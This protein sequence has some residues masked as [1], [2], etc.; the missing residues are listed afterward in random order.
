M[1]IYMKITIKKNPEGNKYV[2]TNKSG[3]DLVQ[4]PLLNK[5]SLFSA[6]EINDLNLR[7]IVTPHDFSLQDLVE[8]TFHTLNEKSTH[9][10]KHIYL[11][12][13]QD[14]NE[15]LF[16]ALTCKYPVEL[17]PLIYTPY[18]GEACEKF[19]EIYRH[20]RGVFI[21]YE[22]RFHLDAILSHPR[23]NDTR[24]IVVSDGERILG[25]GD[26]G[27]GG[28]GIPIGKLS[29]Y[30]ACAGIAPQ[31]TLPI[32]LDVGTNNENL[33]ANPLYIGAR[34]KRIDG[35]EYDAFIET[36]INT[37]KK[38]FPNVVLQWE[39]FAQHHALKLLN[40]YK[41]KLCSFNDDIQGTA[42][43]VSGVLFAATNGSGV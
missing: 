10:E 17:M 13:L 18:V 38:K 15:T 6:D 29:L 24:M 33:L 31:K 21:R 25:L 30:T 23:F 9:L 40:R 28:M 26:Q 7:G 4:D 41:N 2:E 1:E 3:Y 16:Y 39:D 35:E 32:L 19:S 42:A 12:A 11:R 14:R 36:F 8:K 22:D 34:H 5:G 20:P 37:V 43:I 27:A